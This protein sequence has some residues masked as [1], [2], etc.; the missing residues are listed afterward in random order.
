MI[1]RDLMFAQLACCKGGSRIC[2]GQ[3]IGNI[4]LSPR[5]GLRKTSE[6][7]EMDD[8]RHILGFEDGKFSRWPD[9]RRFALDRAVARVR[10]HNQN[11]TVAARA[12]AERKTVCDL[13]YRVATRRQSLSLP[14]ILSIRLRRL[15]R[16]LSYFTVF[17]RDL[18]PGMQGFVPLSSRVSRNQSASYPLS[19][20]SHS[21]SGRPF[22][23]AAAPV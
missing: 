3:R 18:R 2:L 17:L 19:A 9:L 23:K 14:N 10:I 21:A 5:A 22:I 16:R 12:M 1:D 13:S 7:C 8:L 4:E 15:Y 20:R 6:T 11:M